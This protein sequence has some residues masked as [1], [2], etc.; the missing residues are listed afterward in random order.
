[1]LRIL[2]LLLIVISSFLKLRSQ[3]VPFHKGINLT[4][5]F[6]AANARQIQFT[7]YT[8]KDFE[9][10]KSLGCDVIRLP[11]NLHFMTNGAP[12]YNIDPLFYTFLDQVI[13]WAEELNIHLILD[14]HTF[15]PAANTDP[16]VGII[17]EKVWKQVASYYKDRSNY[18]YYEVLNEPHGISDAQWN[19]IQQSVVNAIR[20]V[21]TK[22]TIIIGPAGWNSYHNLAL[23]PQYN[24]DNLIYTFHFYDPFVFTHQ[25]ATWGEPSMG[26]L[27]EVPFPYQVNEMPVFPSS[28][29]GTWV[30]S[31]FNNYANEGTVSKVKEL[32][33]IAVQFKE[34]RNVSIFCG[35]FGVYIPNSNNED[36]VFW[37]DIVRKYLEEKGIAWTSWDYHG[38]FGLYNENGNDLFDHDL[39]VPLLQA[40]GMNAPPQ[41]EFILKP[42]SI[43]FPIY[44]D[45]I[46]S[47]IFESSYSSG[48]LDFY[49]QTQ[50]NNGEYCLYWGGAEQYN[51]IGFD[52][53]PN[54]DLSYLL[55][56]NYALDFWIRGDS[57]GKTFDIRFVD[58]KT[59]DP[60]DHPWRARVT[61]N[62][63][64]AKWD[65]QWHHIRIP[66][67]NFTEQGSWDNNNWYN[68]QGKFDWKAIDRLE[69]VAEQSALQNVKFWFDHIQISSDATTPVENLE[70]DIDVIIYPNPAKD[71]LRIERK[72]SE[73]LTYQVINNFGQILQ[74]SNFQTQ[75]EINLADLPKGLY[76]LRITN[77]E[78]LFKIIKLVKS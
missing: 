44:T 65:N 41:T 61:I 72:S 59:N 12:N 54:K 4:N 9:Q 50:P 2:I 53:K 14:N 77:E 48:T 38:G 31:A 42:D 20:T 25:G 40:L 37:Y 74:T 6:Q 78:K 17:L 22:H 76:L 7:K 3:E 36:R 39:N 62:E 24:D 51:I 58:S 5:W 15:D 66:L 52:F 68:P 55:N 35:E 29:R 56:N 64:L 49:S 28:L 60:G 11:I 63:S 67:K 32:I 8:K 18:I 13:D 26:P 27:A 43:G 70:Y 34:S 23:M 57:P 73:K 47:K 46:E 1:M 30:E 71:Y 45:Y 16:N 75:T 21:D 33:D 69:I 10:I 19:A